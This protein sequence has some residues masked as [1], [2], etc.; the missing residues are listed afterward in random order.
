MSYRPNCHFLLPYLQAEIQIK[1]DG[2]V[3]E[4]CAN[5]DGE[6]VFDGRWSGY[7]QI[8]QASTGRRR[9]RQ[10]GRDESQIVPRDGIGRRA[11]K[12]ITSCPQ[13]GGVP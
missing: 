7:S 10:T 5:G 13:P 2:G 12:D 6:V 1:A 11:G 4:R 8:P 3:V 9:I